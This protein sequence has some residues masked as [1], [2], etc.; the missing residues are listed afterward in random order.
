[1]KLLTPVLAALLSLTL[2]KPLAQQT[3]NIENPNVT[4]IDCP[5]RPEA[6]KVSASLC[7]ENDWLGY[8]HVFVTCE[9]SCYDLV[10]QGVIGNFGDGVSSVIWP[11]GQT[12]KFFSARS[13]D[14][15]AGPWDGSFSGQR[16]VDWFGEGPNDKNP[17]HPM[18]NNKIKS[19]KCSHADTSVNEPT[20]KVKRENAPEATEAPEE[21]STG[22]LEQRAVSESADIA[23]KLPS[24]CFAISQH[25][26]A[27]IETQLNQP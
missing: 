6:G 4:E 10:D 18:L 1:M 23:G 12:C 11:V 16:D 26:F 20:S 9:G 22:A 19:F 5:V 7:S 25:I 13:C 8:C 21:S 14:W 3:N 2:A 17:R 15:T 27:I 24:P